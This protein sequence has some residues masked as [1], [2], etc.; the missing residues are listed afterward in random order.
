MNRSFKVIP[1][2]KIQ[3]A[4]SKTRN[5][6][7]LNVMTSPSSHPA[8]AHFS[9]FPISS[10]IKQ[11]GERQRF[12]QN[13]LMWKQL[14][15]CGGR[16]A[17]ITCPWE[18]T[19]SVHP[20]HQH[21]LHVLIWQTHGRFPAERVHQAGHAAAT[22]AAAAK[23]RGLPGLRETNKQRNQSAFSCWMWSVNGVKPGLYYLLSTPW[24]CGV[25]LHFSS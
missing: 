4:S 15:T 12:R 10:V 20:I 21:W 5:S 9:S 13:S 6:S 16:T 24:W 3:G 7:R 1:R 23:D 18:T 14:T 8:A 17:N 11:Q 22:A 2:T 25:I 19:A